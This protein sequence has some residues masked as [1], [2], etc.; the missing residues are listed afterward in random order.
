V[1]KKTALDIVKK[2]HDAQKILFSIFDTYLKDKIKEDKNRNDIDEKI[3]KGVFASYHTIM[4]TIQ[5]EIFKEYPEVKQLFE[6]ENE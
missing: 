4:N 6:D 3:Y 1:D 5:N 2:S